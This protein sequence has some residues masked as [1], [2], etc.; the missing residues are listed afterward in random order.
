[1]FLISFITG[2]VFFRWLSFIKTSICVD[3][4]IS[5]LVYRTQIFGYI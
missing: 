2:L 4:R 3:V 5:V 1:M